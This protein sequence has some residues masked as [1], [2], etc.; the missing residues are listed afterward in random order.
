MMLSKI[1]DPTVADNTSSKITRQWGC[2]QRNGPWKEPNLMAWLSKRLTS[3]MN[4][5]AIHKTHSLSTC[6][7]NRVRPMANLSQTA[8][9]C[10]KNSRTDPTPTKTVQII[11]WWWMNFKV[12][13]KKVNACLKFDASSAASFC[14]WYMAHN[15]SGETYPYIVCHTFTSMIDTT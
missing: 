14:T 5:D 10:H 3:I 15:T 9:W 8:H 7:M 6:K 12:I 4:S 1:T 11:T 13:R 2:K